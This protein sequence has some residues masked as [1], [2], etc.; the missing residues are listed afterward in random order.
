MSS[1]TLVWDETKQSVVPKTERPLPK[2]VN[3]ISD[4]KEDVVFPI[5]GER[6]SSRGRYL[7][8]VRARGCSVVG[9]DLPPPPDNP[10][11]TAPGDGGNWT[12]PEGLDYWPKTDRT[13]SPWKSPWRRWRP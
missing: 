3:L 7:A 11:G 1:E 5:T 2:R 4:F 10:T 12:T 9:N 13:D 6:I 8:E